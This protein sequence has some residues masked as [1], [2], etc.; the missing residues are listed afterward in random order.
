[1]AA[2]DRQMFIG[3]WSNAG[4]VWMTKLQPLGRLVSRPLGSLLIWS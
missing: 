3:D 1:M 4:H 2:G